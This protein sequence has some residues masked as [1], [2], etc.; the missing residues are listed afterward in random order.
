MTF[1]Y[2]R[3]LKVLCGISVYNH[4]DCDRPCGICYNQY[5]K[6]RCGYYKGWNLENDRNKENRLIWDIINDKNLALL[7]IRNEEFVISELC[8]AILTDNLRIEIV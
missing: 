2:I 7:N 1:Y 4:Y 8:K 5:N 3:K 6:I